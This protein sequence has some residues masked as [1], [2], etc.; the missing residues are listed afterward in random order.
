MFLPLSMA[1][2]VPLNRGCGHLWKVQPRPIVGG[3]QL[4]LV[5]V[6]EPPKRKCDW[7]RKMPY[8]GGKRS[9]K[10]KVLDRDRVSARLGHQRS[11]SIR[12]YLKDF[13]DEVRRCRPN[14]E[15][16]GTSYT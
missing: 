6:E 4:G 11:S 3:V 10:K 5:M 8:Q 7:S 15:R 9:E 13:L 14:L 16:S 12:D 1:E 2:E